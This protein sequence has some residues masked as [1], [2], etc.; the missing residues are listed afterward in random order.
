MALVL[1]T[2]GL[3]AVGLLLWK[4][5]RVAEVSQADT[6]GLPKGSKVMPLALAEIPH[7]LRIL[8]GSTVER[9]VDRFGA[10]WLARRYFIGGEQN[11]WRSAA[12]RW[13]V[14]PGHP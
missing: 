6:K 14:K 5:P 4:A 10:E 9:S 3:F 7:P 2:S 11:R 12:R 8:A 13:R 1:A